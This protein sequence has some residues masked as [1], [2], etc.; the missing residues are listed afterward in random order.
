MKLYNPPLNLRP[1]A[2]HFKRSH[3]NLLL[4]SSL[5]KSDFQKGPKLQIIKVKHI[6]SKR[7][8]QL[9][10]NKS[11]MC[12]KDVFTLETANASENAD[13][14][15]RTFTPATQVVQAY[16]GED[17]LGLASASASPPFTLGNL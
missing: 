3:Y 14:S 4:G 2:E 17:S 6:I 8:A 11:N 10:N 12:S 13:G 9:V 7:C 1:T 5:T 16:A 15:A